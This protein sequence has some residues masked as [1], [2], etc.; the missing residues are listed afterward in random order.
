MKREMEILAKQLRQGAR[1][2]VRSPGFSLAAIVVLAIGIGANTVVFSAVNGILL[3]TLPYPEAERLVSLWVDNRAQGLRRDLTSFPDFE[4]WRTMSRTIA[5]MAAAARVRLTLGSGEGEPE[6][7]M[8]AEVSHELFT[9]LGTAPAL[10]RT[11][12][13]EEER[14]GYE[15]VVIL[16]HD[17][18]MRRFGG[19]PSILNQFI[20]LKGSRYGVV[21]IMPRGFQFPEDA[22]V[23]VP[24]APSPMDRQERRFLWLE[25]IG[26][27]EPGVSLAQ[28]REE[29]A[30]IA[31]RLQLL[32]PLTNADQGITV[33]PLSERVAA[34]IRPTLLLLQAAV[35]LVLL[36]ACSNVANLMLA[37][38]AGRLKEVAICSALGAGRGRVLRQYLVESFLLAL[39]GGAVG[40]LLAFWTLKALKAWSPVEIPQV[41]SLGLDPEVLVFA[42]GLSLV[43]GVLF[44]LLPALRL[45]G[46]GSPDL[47]K[48]GGGRSGVGFAGS[49]L[50]QALVVSEIAVALLLLV[51]AGLLVRT[52]QRL[53]QADPGFEPEGIVT[54]QLQLPPSR[55]QSPLAV[56]GF[57]QD[58]VERTEALPGVSSAASVST[59]LGSEGSRSDRFT[60]YDQ[61]PADSDEVVEVG[62]DS[63]TPGLFSTLGVPLVAGRDFTAEDNLYSPPVVI[64]NQAMAKRYW[65]GE[66]PV[67]KRFKFGGIRTPDPWMEIVGVVGD[68][69]RSILD[70][71]VRPTAYRPYAQDPFPVLNLVARTRP[72]AG[73]LAEEL[74]A[75]VWSL[76]STQP[77]IRITTA[78]E[79]LAEQWADRRLRTLLLAVLSL[80]ALLLAVI[81]TYGLTA[82][83]VSRQTHDIGIRMAL[84]AEGQAVLAP[85]LRQGLRLALLG[86]GIGLVA[87]A[88]VTRFMRSLLFGVSSLDPL[89]YV[90]VALLLLAAAA[91]ASYLP[92]RRATRLDPVEALYQR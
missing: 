66:S 31:Y 19:D 89:V 44:G 35:A 3:R 24:L 39:A 51:A 13:P 2:L 91:L 65:P 37:R 27:L 92:A 71:E 67:G 32:H 79:L 55:Y 12:A 21:G 46:G 82:Y 23:W 9:V 47:L 33:E 6:Q 73:P 72:D 15:N 62:V 5:P 17:L 80:V 43:T 84:G 14:R 64:I 85:I 34:Q 61:P 81:G 16:S 48:E 40:V 54:L 68:L 36:I 25:V 56:A 41:E 7:I 8:G 69:K 57:A 77:I 59:L 50:R 53:G 28:A 52:I 58:L 18:W 42:L 74:R 86:V 22:E 60:L 49:R 29:M 4:D 76:D 70:P 38:G 45:S 88:V 20:D 87:A 10:G 26:R 78:E 30:A 63:V 11:F 90:T 1:A 83:L 75:Q